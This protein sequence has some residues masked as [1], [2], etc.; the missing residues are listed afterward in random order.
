[1]PVDLEPTSDQPEQSS[2]TLF[3]NDSDKERRP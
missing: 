1:M 2:S 3:F